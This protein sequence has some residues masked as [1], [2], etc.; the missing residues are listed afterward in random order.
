MF[1]Y[2]AGRALSCR[3]GV[4]LGLDNYTSTKNII[5]HHFHHLNIKV[6][7]IPNN[8]IPPRKKSNLFLWSLW[9]LGLRRP[10]IFHQGGLSY[11]PKIG[12]VT[13]NSYLIGYWQSESFFQDCK[14]IIKSDFEFIS[15]PK[16]QNLDTYQEISET[17]ST[18]SLHIRRGDYLTGKDESI[19]GM[20][21][22]E[23]YDKSVIWIAEHCQITPTVFVFSDDPVWVAEN[24]KLPFRT[25]VI[26]HN[27]PENAIEDLRL[28]T[29]CNHHVIANSSFSWWGAWLGKNKRKIIVAPDRWFSNPK[30]SN[31]N[32]YCKNWVRIKN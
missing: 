27:S 32:I 6:K 4:S 29:I 14:D 24:F 10:K 1:Q 8:L 13:D 26:G 19:F 30:Y 22:Q 7:K 17:Q 21:S 9:R 28:M 11:N 25:R 23:Y 15:S 12:K 5:P 2:A 18:I 3:L 16:L 20:C 31:P